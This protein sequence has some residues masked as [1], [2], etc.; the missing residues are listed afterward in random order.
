MKTAR[1]LFVKAVDGL[2]YAVALNVLVV[3]VLGPLF[4]LVTGTLVGLKWVLFLVGLLLLGVGGVKLRPPP[5]GRESSRLGIANSTAEDGFGGRVGRL[6]PV[7]WYDPGPTDHLSDGARFLLA[8]VM[9]WA[10][11]FALEAVFGVGVPTVG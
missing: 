11:S 4:V 5:P 1:R 9:A 7:A 10:V 8:G 6:P 2:Q 3:V